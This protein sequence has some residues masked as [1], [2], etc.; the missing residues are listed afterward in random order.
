MRRSSNYLT[1]LLALATALPISG[2]RLLAQD[3]TKTQTSR[4][5]QQGV[6]Q[7]GAMHDMA[8]MSMSAPMSTTL[9]VPTSRLGSGT[10]WLPDSTRLREAMQMRG[11]WMLS[12][13]TKAYTQYVNQGT[14][15]G[16]TQFGVTDWEMLMAMRPIKRG[17]LRLTL[18]TTIEPL[19]LGGSGYPLLLQTGGTYEH[20]FLHD[21]QHPHNAMMELSAAYEYPIANRV[22][23]SLYTAAVGEPAIG[24]VA[25]MHRPSAASDPLAPLG[26]HWQDASHQSFG[27]VTWGINTR[28]L[29]LEGSAF[30]PREPDEHHLF[31]DYR[32]ARLDSYSGRLTW[33]PTPR[34]VAASWW[35]YLNSHERLDPTAQMHRYGA[36]VLT[37]TRGLRGGSWSSTFVWAMN[38]HHHGGASHA[39]LHGGPGASPHH[40]ASSMLAE[41]NLEIGKRTAVFAR[42]ERVRKN[43]EELGFLG[44]DLTELYDVRS[45]TLG[46]LRQ[47]ARVGATTFGLGARG[48]VNFVPSTLL[49]TYGTRHPMGVAVYGQLRV[50]NVR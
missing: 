3:T 44:G 41:S 21:R 47:I 19:T 4:D 22:A 10:S 25:S 31:M 48:S 8:G 43:G 36:S 7:P 17:S 38:L 50:G 33:A 26:H 34:V 30:N 32:G 6:T 45:Y 14:K 28:T 20:A 24:P 42:V 40:H 39:I 46:G 29:K 18:M 2:E 5:P 11:A 12:L 35:G 9:G 16:D 15:R 1:C 49:A 13:Q 37:D 23:L 27:V